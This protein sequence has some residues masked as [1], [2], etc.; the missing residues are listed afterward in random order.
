MIETGKEPTASQLNVIRKIVEDKNSEV[1]I[2]LKDPNKPDVADQFET[3]QPEAGTD[4]KRV[5]GL[6]RRFYRGDDISGAVGTFMP[7]TEADPRIPSR[8]P[9]KPVVN[10]RSQMLQWLAQSFIERG[11]ID[12]EE[13]TTAV[14]ALSPID[15]ERS[16]L[17]DAYKI[18]QVNENY[19][20]VLDSTKQEKFVDVLLGEG[21]E[22]GTDVGLRID[23]NAFENSL[24]KVAK[25]ELDFPI[26]IVTI[27]SEGGK[28][29]GK[30]ILG[31]SAIGA[32][33]NPTF[34]IGSEKGSLAI[35]AGLRKT[36]LATVEGKWVP[37]SEVP[38][39]TGKGWTR[40]GMDPTR[41]SYFYD[42][43][44][45]EPIKRGSL[46]VSFGNTVFVRDADPMTR[47]EAA[48]VLYMPTRTVGDST[49]Y[50]GDEGARVIKTKS[51]KYRVYGH[52]KKLLGVASSEKTAERILRSG[53]KKV[54][55]R[56]RSARGLAGV[57]GS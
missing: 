35:A 23:I 6:I 13:W 43:E 28:N 14:N 22:E 27:H 51:G 34:L 26:Y 3:L 18:D 46:A 4:P 2:D 17:P 20:M 7:A 40:A 54:S 8:V 50:T 53:T 44:T 12:K 25:G 16:Q 29:I 47:E 57:G 38:N 5:I 19:Q 15:A 48:N 39:V 41:H 42:K 56:G 10:N 30:D 45:G 31:Y 24:K 55:V 49:G 33:S 37:L 32:V 52:N 21:P 9:A 11:T 36:T 1:F